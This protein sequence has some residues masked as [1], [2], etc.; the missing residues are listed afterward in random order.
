M[1]GIKIMHQR[2]SA[3]NLTRLKVKPTIL[4]SMMS[5]SNLRQICMC[6]MLLLCMR[7]LWR[8]EVADLRDFINFST[9]HPPPESIWRWVFF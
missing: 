1:H 4:G 5:F 7:V 6:C 9:Y 8:R 2:K 3:G